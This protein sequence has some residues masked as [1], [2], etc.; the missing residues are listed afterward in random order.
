MM[1]VGHVCIVPGTMQIVPH[2]YFSQSLR[3]GIPGDPPGIRTALPLSPTTP[4]GYG[5]SVVRSGPDG[6]R[7]GLLMGRHIGPNAASAG[8]KSGLRRTR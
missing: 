6:R 5:Y 2:L 3:F 7:P 1:A 4:A 8:G